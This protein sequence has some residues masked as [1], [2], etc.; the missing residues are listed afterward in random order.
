MWPTLRQPIVTASQ[1]AEAGR[2]SKNSQGRSSLRVLFVS[3]EV[4]PLA[5]SGGLADVSAA[6]PMALAELGAEMQLLLPG[7]PAALE[8]ATNRSVEL[9]IADFMDSGV[10]RLI[11]ARTPDTGLPIWLVDCPALFE[12]SGGLY[13]DGSGADWPDNAKRFAVLSSA[14]AWLALGKWVPDWRADVVHANDWHAGLVAPLIA[15]ASGKKPGTIFTMHNLAYQGLFPA[16]VFRELGLPPETFD[17]DGLEFYGK[18]CFL[19]AGMRYSDQLTTVSPTYAREILTPEFGYGLEGLLQVRSRDLSGILNGVDYRIWNPSKDPHLAN[20]YD[21]QDLAAKRHCKTALQRELHLEPVPD[22]PLV[23]YISRMTDQ[24]MADSVLEALPAIL[25]RGLQFALLGDGD[26]SIEERVQNAGRCYAG[27][28]S[29]RIG[30]QES[31]AHQFLGGADILLHPARFEPCGLT[32]LYA[33]RYGTLP[34]VRRVGGLADTIV[35]ANEDTMRDGTATGFTFEEATSRD[36]VSALDRALSIYRQPVVWR[37]MQRRA[38]SRD[39]GWKCSAQRYLELYRR[40]APEV[41]Q[42]RVRGGIHDAGPA[43]RDRKK[44]PSFLGARRSAGGQGP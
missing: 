30:Y 35:G 2:M 20:N 42:G 29:A 17:P 12:R 16:S 41:E 36:M 40:V 9:E 21:A 13:Q 8:V 15:N 34:I 43:R 4:Y 38:M 23:I 37:K 6:L 31:L 3:S 33:M 5:K 11:A 10:T 1:L 14:A 24:K 28:V 26:P 32:Q 44:R 22:V 18:V 25:D 7:Y 27:Q 19:K 39:F